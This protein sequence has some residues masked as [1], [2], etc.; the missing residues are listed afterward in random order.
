MLPAVYS[1]Y[2]PSF[3]RLGTSVGGSAFHSLRRLG[4]PEK[5]LLG[6]I[7]LGFGDYCGKINTLNFRVKFT[8]IC[9]YF[10]QHGLVDIPEVFD[11]RRHECLLYIEVIIQSKKQCVLSSCIVSIGLW[12]ISRGFPTKQ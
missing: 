9:T 11:V 3:S 2:H 10:L 12:I 6:G 1:P 7:P 5:A 8:C 4:V